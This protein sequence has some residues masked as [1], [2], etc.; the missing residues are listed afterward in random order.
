MAE[1]IRKT[2]EST[3][4]TAGAITLKKTVSI[5]VAS[6]DSGCGRKETLIARADQ[7]L[8]H[9]KETGRNK[10]CLYSELPEAAAASGE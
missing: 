7:A 3:V 10:V 4:I 5:G 1:R 9:A 6:H 2:V 8:Y